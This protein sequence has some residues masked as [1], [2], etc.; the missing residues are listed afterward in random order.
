MIKTLK[1]NF[2]KFVHWLKSPKIDFSK[3]SKGEKIWIEVEY[4]E[5]E[6]TYKVVY[7]S[8]IGSNCFYIERKD[9]KKHLKNKLNYEK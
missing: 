1:Y 6:D 3:L 9:I 4:L 2:K 8:D 7:R 5:K